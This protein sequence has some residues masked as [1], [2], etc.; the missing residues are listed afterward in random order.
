MIDREKDGSQVVYTLSTG[1]K[2]ITVSIETED[3]RVNE[4]AHVSSDSLDFSDALGEPADNSR[5][6]NL[7]ELGKELDLEFGD[8]AV[9]VALFQH[10]FSV[11]LDNSSLK[12]GESWSNEEKTLYPLEEYAEDEENQD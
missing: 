11:K 1:E 12:A 2:E 7:D 6:E 3:E 5:R 9:L 4:F 10:D 8:D